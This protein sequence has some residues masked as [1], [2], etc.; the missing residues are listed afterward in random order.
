MFSIALFSSVQRGKHLV[1]SNVEN[2]YLPPTL[3]LSR[4]L[5]GLLVVLQ[6]LDLVEVFV[7]RQAGSPLVLGLVEPLLTIIDRGMSSDSDQQ[8]QDF[9]RRAADI[10]R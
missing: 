6:V 9:L 10:F 4:A 3:K 8:E 2:I 5:V 7:A 1:P